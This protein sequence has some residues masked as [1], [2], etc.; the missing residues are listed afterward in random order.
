MLYIFIL[1]GLLPSFAWLFFF[2]KEDTHPEPKKMI[3]LV[4][5]LGGIFHRP[6]ADV[7]DFSY[8]CPNL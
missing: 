5:F 3:A 2:L 8:Q 4:F 1:L 7:R 6:F